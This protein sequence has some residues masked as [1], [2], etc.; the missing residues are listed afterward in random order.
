MRVLGNII[1]LNSGERIIRQVK[2][3]KRE[4]FKDDYEI[5]LGIEVAR[6]M[7]VERQTIYSNVTA[8]MVDGESR[9]DLENNR[10]VTKIDGKLYKEIV[11][12][13]SEVRY[14]EVT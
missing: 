12:E 8:S 4:P 7:S 10:K 14:E 6:G 9:I 2:Q 3:I 1:G 11:D 13:N 5:E